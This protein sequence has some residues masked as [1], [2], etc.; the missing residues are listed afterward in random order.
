MCLSVRDHI[1]GTTRP[2]FTKFFVLVTHGRGSIL[3]WSRSD[4]LRI[5]GF[6]DDV[7]FA[8][9]LRLLD[10]GIGNGISK[11]RAVGSVFRYAVQGTVY[12]M[13]AQLLPYWKG[14]IVFG[15]M[16]RPFC[17]ITLDIPV[18]DRIN[19]NDND[20]DDDDDYNQSHHDDDDAVGVRDDVVGAGG[21]QLAERNSAVGAHGAAAVPG[22]VRGGPA[23]RR[24]R[25]EPEPASGRDGLLATP[26]RRQPAAPL[27][28]ARRDA[29]RAD[30][31]LCDHPAGHHHHRTRSDRRPLAFDRYDTIRYDTSNN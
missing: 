20:N 30:Q 13:G 5:S 7:I 16:M 27:Q 8:D 2:S 23:L 14:H 6:M 17:L 12:Y 11:Y 18:A 25:L 10:V 1:F 19:D 9:M 15:V 24:R 3:L 28:H 26:R 31:P 22:R 21:R 29:V 4:K